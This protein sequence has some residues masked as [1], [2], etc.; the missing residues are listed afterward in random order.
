MKL[1]LVETNEPE[2]DEE[3]LKIGCCFHGYELPAA[4]E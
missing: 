1:E 3:C 2:G 4:E